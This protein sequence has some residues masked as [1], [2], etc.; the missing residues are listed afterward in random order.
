MYIYMYV[1]IYICIYI[2]MLQMY[3]CRVLLKIYIV[4]FKHFTSVKLSRKDIILL[5]LTCFLMYFEINK[6]RNL[7]IPPQIC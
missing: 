1:R 2:Y 3:S 4:P 7:K 5:I 6:L